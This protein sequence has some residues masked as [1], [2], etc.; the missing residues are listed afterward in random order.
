MWGRTGHLDLDKETVSLYT[1]CG[2]QTNTANLDYPPWFSPLAP[3]RH[4]AVLWIM[5]H[6]VHYRLLTQ[7]RLS[8]LDYVDCMR[9]ARWKLYQ[10]P[11]R[12]RF[13]GRY[14]DVINWPQ[15]WSEL[16]GSHYPPLPG[17][18]WTLLYIASTDLRTSYINPCVYYFFFFAACIDAY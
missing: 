16:L 1:S 7:R 4:S 17:P 10:H 13:T 5:A 9:R 11:C 8:L 14:L 6:L 3:Q 2:P 12:P 15:Y 18:W